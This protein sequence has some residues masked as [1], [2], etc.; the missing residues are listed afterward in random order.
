MKHPFHNVND[1]G[2][3]GVA[4]P[5]EVLTMTHRTF[6]WLVYPEHTRARI[7]RAAE[8]AVY[9]SIGI[10]KA[11][12]TAHEGGGGTVVVPAGD[13]LIGPLELR[14]RVRL[15]LEP[16]ARLWG[17]P[18]MADYRPADG[19]AFPSYTHECGFGRENDRMNNKLR[20]ISATEAE[21]IA[22][23]GSG[24]ISAQSPAFIIPWMNTRPRHGGD[25]DRPSDTFLFHRCRRVMLQDFQLRDTPCWSIVFDHC[26]EV[27][28]RGIDLRG[29]DVINSDGIDLV[30]TSDVTISDCRFHVT[31]DVICLKNMT[32]GNTMRNVAVTNCVMRTLCNGLKIG[33]DTMGNF[34]DIVVS[35]LVIH[36]SEDDV[37]GGK[38]INLSTI[39]GGHVRN[40]V[41]SNVVMRNVDCAFYVVV[42]CRSERQ[43]EFR[44]PRPGSVSGVTLANIRAEG[45]KYTSFVAGHPDSP[46]QDVRLSNIRVCKAKDFYTEHPELVRDQPEHY[47]SPVMF[48]SLEDGDQVPAWGLYLRHVVEITVDGMTVVT[49]QPDIRE[50]VVEDHCREVRLSGFR[51]RVSPSVSET[52]RREHVLGR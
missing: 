12:D 42:G 4:V 10:Q 3:A 40:V 41:I 7:Y 8:G 17:S 45:V 43:R 5:S 28:V 16:G 39:D 23:T 44:E 32:G 31:D 14:S 24:R 33:T 26:R 52:D 50:P 1:F 25:L 49:E 51:A 36:N 35:N 34:E 46:V 9:D 37:R 2:A 18:D 19:H 22:I 6:K 15:H 21:D 11:I 47:P 13:Y 38:G 30:D 29:M 48:G 20:L 27:Q